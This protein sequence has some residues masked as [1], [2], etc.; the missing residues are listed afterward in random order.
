MQIKYQS[1]SSEPK[2]SDKPYRDSP[3]VLQTLTVAVAGQCVFF[4]FFLKSAVEDLGH[5]LC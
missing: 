5:V 1:S 2:V 4:E 3:F